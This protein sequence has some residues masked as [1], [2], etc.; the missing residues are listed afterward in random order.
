MRQRHIQEMATWEP[1]ER[2]MVGARFV[3]GLFVGVPLGVALWTAILVW[4]W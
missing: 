4:V 2:P 3:Q 1:D